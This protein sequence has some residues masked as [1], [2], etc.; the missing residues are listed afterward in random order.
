LRTTAPYE[1]ASYSDLVGSG[2]MAAVKMCIVLCCV[3][4]LHFSVADG[5]LYYFGKTY[6]HHLQGKYE[7][8][9]ENSI[10]CTGYMKEMGHM[11]P[12]A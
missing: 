9:W 8:T 6:C 10:I 7:E 3:A 1:F 4:K 11:V 12:G 2:V 5:Y